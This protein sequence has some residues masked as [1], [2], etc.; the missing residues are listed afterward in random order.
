MDTLSIGQK[1]I[2]HLDRYR[3]TDPTD[4]YNIPWDTTQDGIATS[5]RISRAHASI[6]L[7]K[8]REKE[9]VD[10]RQ[11]HIRGGKVKRKSY[12]LTPL[13][14]EDV[15]KI[16]D[17]A[18]KEGIDINA[19]LDLK[20]QDAN[21]LLNDLSADD[22]FALGCAC[23]FR[24][25]MP[26]EALPK[27]KKSIVP[28]DVTGSTVIDEKLRN[29][30]L[31]AATDEQKS[32]WHSYAADYWIEKRG[33]F[34]E[35]ERIHERVY[36]L[37]ESGRER[38][39]C[40]MIAGNMYDLIYT[41]NDDLHDTLMKITRIPEQQAVDVLSTRIEIDLNSDD[42]DDAEG[43]IT[44]LSEYD[45]HSAILYSA[46]LESQKGHPDEALGILSPFMKEDTLAALYAA[47]I[48]IQQNEYDRA[49]RSIDSVGSLAGGSDY[50]IGI[51]KFVLLA[52]IEKHEG[53][54]QDAY[55]HLMKARASVPDKGK[56]RIDA[57]VKGL[58]LRK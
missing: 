16:R 26:I 21:I 34:D 23:A 8:L 58:D 19:L 54:V 27:S 5:L 55:S 57:L 48:F 53:R 39:A 2:M 4:I 9:K 1:I 45:R 47:R 13:G 29:N 40:K 22:A 41:A 52:Q 14:A 3:M 36:H 43:T 25:P 15:S 42:L 30:I 50:N 10:E 37:V 12:L 33:M 35:I 20:R 28:V 18:E 31:S 49:R 46:I 7:K 32:S 38:E 17:F 44:K 11:T 24:I 6:E 56:K 51:E